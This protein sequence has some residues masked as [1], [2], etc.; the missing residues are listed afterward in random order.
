MLL[1]PVAAPAMAGPNE[2][3]FLEGLVGTWKGKGRITGPDGGPIACR[4]TFR[5]VGERLNFNGRCTGGGTAQSFSGVIRYNDDEGRF[6]STSSGTTVAGKKSGTSLVFASTQKEQRG[7]VSSTM[8]LS[9]SALKMQFKAVDA[10]TGEESS[11]SIPFSK[12]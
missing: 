9:P 5:T 10:R 1:V 11:G 4:L 8:T 2:T 6:E 3:A 12:S 7:T